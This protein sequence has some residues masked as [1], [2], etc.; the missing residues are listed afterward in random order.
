MQLGMFFTGVSPGG[1]A[2]NVWVAVLDGNIDLSITMTAISTLG[3][4]IT[5]PFWLFTL[6]V[7]IFKMG[8][9]K[10]PYKNISSYAIALI[11]PLFIGFLIQR[12]QTI[13]FCFS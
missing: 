1:G 13:I 7:E 5:M 6:G 12:L 8:N 11:V 9:V 4:F 10:V 2:S 3:A